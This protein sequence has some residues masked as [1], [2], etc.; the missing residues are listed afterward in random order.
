MTINQLNAEGYKIKAGNIKPDSDREI[1]Y[2]LL[3]HKKTYNYIT[4][5]FDGKNF[6]IPMIINNGAIKS[7][8]AKNAQSKNLKCSYR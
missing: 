2:F 4:W 3:L 1:K 8:V 5:S 6:T 7:C